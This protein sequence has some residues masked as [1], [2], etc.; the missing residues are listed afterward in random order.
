MLDCKRPQHS[1][2][3]NPTTSNICDLFFAT[4]LTNLESS[5]LYDVLQGHAE[6]ADDFVKYSQILAF[7]CKVFKMNNIKVSIG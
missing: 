2:L 5:F 6:F 4:T 7:I 3:T 1:A